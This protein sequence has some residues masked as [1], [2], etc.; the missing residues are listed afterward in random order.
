MRTDELIARLARGAGAVE[1]N[2]VA[3]RYGTAIGWGGFGATLVMALFLGVRPDLREA[4]SL[5]MFWIKLVFPGALFAI[6]LLLAARLARPAMPVGS[7]PRILVVPLI[8]VW[9]MAAIELAGAPPDERASL[10]LGRT[11]DVCPFYVALLSVPIFIGAFW[12]MKRLAP[13]RLV[14]AG[15]A[16]GLVAGALAASIYALHCD[17]MSAAFLGTWYVIGMLIPTAI[18]AALGPKLLRW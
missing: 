18:G 15:A 11:W 5:P 4:I 14:R 7:L 9:V 1:P 6:A 13:T 3:R 10:M 17:E 2:A 8:A 12:A 16:C